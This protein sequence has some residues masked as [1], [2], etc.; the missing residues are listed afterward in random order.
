[1]KKNYVKPITTVLGVD[2][3]THI[4]SGS[5]KITGDIGGDTRIEFGGSSENDPHKEKG[6]DAKLNLWNDPEDWEE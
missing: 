2:M 3:P 4:L 6:G 5:D 1:M